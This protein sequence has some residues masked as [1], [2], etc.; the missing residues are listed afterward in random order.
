MLGFERFN[1]IRLLRL[2]R[3]ADGLAKFSSTPLNVNLFM[4]LAVIKECCRRLYLSLREGSR[5][6]ESYQ[7]ATAG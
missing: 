2:G 1:Q 3:L 4:V 7:K 6:R 5:L